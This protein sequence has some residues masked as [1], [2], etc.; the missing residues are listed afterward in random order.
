MGMERDSETLRWSDS[1]SQESWQDSA[2]I[3]YAFIK[4]LILNEDYDDCFVG[5]LVAQLLVGV[6]L[7]LGRAHVRPR[8]LRQQ[9]FIHMCSNDELSCSVLLHQ[10]AVR[11]FGFPPSC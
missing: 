8:K 6:R 11:D 1:C 10:E 3:Y 7:S 9:P 2:L 5:S 4:R